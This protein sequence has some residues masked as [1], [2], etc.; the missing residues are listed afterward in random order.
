MPGGL[1]GRL[2]EAIIATAAEA[3]N[4]TFTAEEANIWYSISAQERR[5]IAGDNSVDEDANDT[6][7]F[8]IHYINSKNPEVK[9]Y[10][11]SVLM[12]IK[13][14]SPASASEEHAHPSASLPVF[15]SKGLK[16][17]KKKKR[18]RR[19]SKKKKSKTRRKRR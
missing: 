10:I 14:Y 8:K 2:N 6:D 17:E 9:K 15:S 13:G 11:R 7:E 5:G 18:K 4:L 3:G 19:K 12:F 1:S 16:K